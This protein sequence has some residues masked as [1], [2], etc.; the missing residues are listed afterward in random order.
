MPEENFTEIGKM[1]NGNYRLVLT[2]NRV[3]PKPVCNLNF[4]VS[5]MITLL[6][7]MYF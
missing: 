4:K 7:Y 1:Q 6:K 2:Q 5:Y 3:Y